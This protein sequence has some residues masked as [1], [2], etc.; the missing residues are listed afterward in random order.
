MQNTQHS[1]ATKTTADAFGEQNQIQKNIRHPRILLIDDDLTYCKVMGKIAAHRGIDLTYCTSADAIGLINDWTFDSAII[2]FNLGAVTGYEVA[3][4]LETK[5]C[6]L[7][8]LIVSH[9]RQEDLGDLPS[10]VQAFIAKSAGP[11][12]TLTAALA[13]SRRVED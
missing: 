2:D 7:P 10:T 5:E 11:D 6:P 12:Q 1:K 9:S 4:Y 3:S 13:L 8:A